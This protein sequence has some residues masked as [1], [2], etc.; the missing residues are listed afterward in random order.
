MAAENG[1]ASLIP[2]QGRASTAVSRRAV[3]QSKSTEL[4]LISVT[5]ACEKFL[6]ANTHLSRGRVKHYE[7]LFV[8]LNQF[9]HRHQIDALEDLSLDVLTG[10][11]A[12]WH[13]RWHHS[14]GTIRMNI[15]MLRKFFR[16]C[17][18]R[19]WILKNLASQLEVPNVKSRPTLPFSLEEWAKIL[20]VLPSYGT[21]I[22]H[23]EPQRLHALVL[24]LRYSGMRIGDAV[25]CETT[26]IDGDR[27]SFVT[28]KNQVQVC[29]KLPKFV[30]KAL[31]GVPRKSDR[32]FFWNG[33]CALQTAIGNWQERLR[34]LFDRAGIRNG[35]PHRFRDT[36]AFDMAHNGEMTLEELRQALG[37]KTTKTTEK[38][39]SHWIKE[40]QE[41]MEAK[42]ERA[43]QGLDRP[44]LV[45]RKNS[46]R[47]IRNR[48][49]SAARRSA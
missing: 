20:Q 33:T 22:P 47:E 35:H 40:R 27:I 17:T 30:V 44:Q 12:E 24:L 18:A 49:V 46:V 21:R 38:Y 43:W 29:N 16:F 9:L 23:A 41:R 11:R 42:Q 48:V 13:T 31:L 32:Y 5:A 4:N 6:A 1:E 37:H 26:W 19:E 10:F 45:F 15:Q 28:Q 39:Y 34:I 25:R 3:I 36:Y 2:P 14:T 7:L 8:R